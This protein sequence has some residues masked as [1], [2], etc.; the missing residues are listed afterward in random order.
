VD[1][2]LADFAADLRA[3]TPSAAAE[4]VVPDRRELADE[5]QKWQRQLENSLTGKIVHARQVLGDLRLRIQPRRITR[6]MNEETQRLAD[7]EER[8][9]RAMAARIE[10]ELLRIG[11]FKAVIEGF[12]PYLPLARGYCILEKAGTVVASA[13]ALAT[14]DRV[15]LRLGDGTADANIV[16]VRHDN[17]L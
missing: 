10:R 5:L 4:L 17:E 16:E 3:P 6:R 14:G 13:R 15:L 11:Q 2:T 9:N 12:N 8:L 1:V 7:L